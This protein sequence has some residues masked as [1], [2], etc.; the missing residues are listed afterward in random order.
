MLQDQTMDTLLLQAIETDY[1]KVGQYN[2]DA[3]NGFTDEVLDTLI[4]SVVPSPLLRILDAMAGDGNLTQ[5]L[6]TYCRRRG[7]PAPEMVLLECSRVQC[8]VARTRLEDTPAEVI[9][10]DVLRMENFAT[11]KIFPQATFDRVMIKSGNHEIPLARQSELY[12][13][14]YHVLKPGGWFVNLGFLY[15]DVAERDEFRQ[16]VRFKDRT[17]GLFE[18]MRN[19]HVL[20]RSEFYA[21]LHQAGFVDVQCVRHIHYTIHSRIGVQAY[22]PVARWERMHAALQAQWARAMT[23]RRNGRIHFHGDNGILICPGEITLA[24]RPL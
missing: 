3:V 14:V 10:G 19:R 21:R 11:R 24:R 17:A 12:D 15:D 7:I 8:E 2:Q 22:Y 5:R 23:L 13:S 1:D 16:L 9:W 18:A 20:T 4:E 6:Y